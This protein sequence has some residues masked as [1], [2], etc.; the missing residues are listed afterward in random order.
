MSGVPNTQA[1]KN[2]LYV[3]TISTENVDTS[4]ENGIVN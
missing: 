2:Q 3:E 1:V 4:T